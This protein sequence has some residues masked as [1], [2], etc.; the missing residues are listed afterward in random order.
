VKSTGKPVSTR[1]IQEIAVL[2][3]MVLI[4]GGYFLY[5][6]IKA[7]PASSTTNKPINTTFDTDTLTQIEKKDADFPSIVPNDLGRNDPYAP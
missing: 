1:L 4:V 3:A 7:K 5:Q 6:S 2:V